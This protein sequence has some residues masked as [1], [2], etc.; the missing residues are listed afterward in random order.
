MSTWGS[1]PHQPGELAQGSLRWVRTTG[2]GRSGSPAAV[3]LRPRLPAVPPVQAPPPGCP[4]PSLPWLPSLH[5]HFPPPSSAPECHSAVRPSRDAFVC[6]NGRLT[7][8]EGSKGF[9]GTSDTRSSRCA[10]RE[11][12]RGREPPAAERGWVL[13]PVPPAFSAAGEWLG[14]RKQCNIHRRLARG[15]PCAG[16]L[17]THSPAPSAGR[18][19]ETP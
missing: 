16:S 12:H 4:L 1:D 14:L 17:P 3:V 9:P 8:L 11:A 13:C 2:G 19:H 5:A 15:R 18:R 6:S 7:N 10:G